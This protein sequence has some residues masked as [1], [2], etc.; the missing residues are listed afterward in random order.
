MPC[1]G[2]PICRGQG[3]LEVLF[4]LW[5]RGWGGAG[6]LSRGQESREGGVQSTP[7]PGPWQGGAGV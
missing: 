1:I 6:H 3:S 4:L 7:P 2:W 5:F